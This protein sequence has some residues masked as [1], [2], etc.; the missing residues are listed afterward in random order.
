MHACAVG[1]QNPCPEVH[2]LLSSDVLA[3]RHTPRGGGEDAGDVLDA[4]VQT[5]IR[6]DE[7]NETNNETKHE[8]KN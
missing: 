5:A 3:P 1:P 8:A 4:G 7:D 2:C 6:P